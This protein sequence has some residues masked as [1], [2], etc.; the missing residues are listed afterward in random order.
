MA[1][2][3][4]FRRWTRRLSALVLMV[5]ATAA[6]GCGYVVGSAFDPQIRT[7]HVPT[8]TSEVYRRGI[9]FQLT[10]AVQKEIQKRTP[11]RLV[12]GPEADTRLTGKIVETHKDVLG[13]NAFDDP[14]ELQLSLSVEVTWEDVRSGQILAQRRLPLAPQIA[15]LRS[16]ASFAPEVGQSLA[17]GTQTALT[18]L[19]RQI[20]DMMEMPW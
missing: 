4:V 5:W 6:S 2:P 15:Q 18:D 10:E 13:Q 12:K 16:E 9:E 11:F 7:V 3:Q 1:V 14:R 19:S 8:F 20:V 17:T